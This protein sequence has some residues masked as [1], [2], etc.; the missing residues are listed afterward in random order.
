MKMDGLYQNQPP[1]RHLVEDMSDLVTRF[2]EYERRPNSCRQ[3]PHRGRPD[4]PRRVCILGV[5]QCHGYTPF[6]ALERTPAVRF[7]NSP[8]LAHFPLRPIT[9]FMVT[10]WGFV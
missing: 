1:T 7:R 4:R 9:V 5:I 2:S 8:T 6:G 3:S 10:F